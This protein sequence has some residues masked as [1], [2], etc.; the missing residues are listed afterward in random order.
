MTSQNIEHRPCFFFNCGGDCE[1]FFGEE[2]N[3]E[4]Q[5]FPILLSD[6]ILRRCNKLKKYHFFNCLRYV[7]KRLLV[8]LRPTI[9]TIQSQVSQ[10]WR[11]VVRCKV[12]D[13]EKIE[14]F[15]FS[16]APQIMWRLEFCLALYCCRNPEFFF[17]L[18]L[19]KM[20]SI[21][22]C[23]SVGTVEK[24]RRNVFHVERIRKYTRGLLFWPKYWSSM[25][26][27]WSRILRWVDR[28]RMRSCKKN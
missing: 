22:F 13:D 12:A 24:H 4:T 14:A 26:M 10:K 23:K 5:I 25:E 11:V 27:L 21:L 8:L 20:K 7:F 1:V 3:Q 2:A 17:R 18:G 16:D 9:L 19:R 15:F 28:R 6:F